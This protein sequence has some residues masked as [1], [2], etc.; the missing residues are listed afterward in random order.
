MSAII[1]YSL[2]SSTRNELLKPADDMRGMALL[3]TGSSKSKGTLS[4]PMQGRHFK[5]GGGRSWHSGH[6]GRSVGVPELPIL[7]CSCTESKI[8]P[9]VVRI[10][11]QVLDA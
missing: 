7:S 9:A 10:R 5:A 4:S 2:F 11:M 3:I 1:Y 8:E 6:C